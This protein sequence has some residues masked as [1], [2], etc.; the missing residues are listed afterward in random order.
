MSVVVQE[1]PP[2]EVV[3]GVGSGI[4][5]GLPGFPGTA[6]QHGLDG[7]VYPVRDVNVDRVEPEGA[8]VVSATQGRLGGGSQLPLPWQLGFPWWKGW[9]GGK[10][11]DG[12]PGRSVW[13][14]RAP[15]RAY[16]GYVKGLAYYLEH[17]D[18]ARGRWSFLGMQDTAL[19]D[20]GLGVALDIIRTKRRKGHKKGKD[21]EKFSSLVGCGVKW[22]G[23]ESG[24]RPC[25]CDDKR[26]C[27]LC[28]CKEADGLG[29]DACDF[30]YGE[31]L[32]AARLLVGKLECVGSAWEVPL[33]KRLSAELDWLMAVNPKLYRKEANRMLGEMW[34]VI[35]LAYPEGRIGGH[36][37]LQLYGEGNPAEAHFHGH[38]VVAP[39]LLEAAPAKTCRVNNLGRVSETNGW[40]PVGVK[41][42]PGFIPPEVLERQRFDWGRRQINLA[43]RLSVPLSELGVDESSG[44]PELEGDV[45]L[46]YFGLQQGYQK[47]VQRAKGYLGYQ[48]RWPGKDLVSG[49]KGDGSRYTWT[50]PM[51]SKPKPEVFGEGASF[52]GKYV[53]GARPIYERNLSPSDVA[54][55]IWRIDKFPGKCPRLRWRGFLST[56][57]VSKVMDFLGWNQVKVEPEELEESQLDNVEELQGQLEEVQQEIS[58]LDE[59]VSPEE[60]QELQEKLEEIQEKM[61]ELEAVTPA[62]LLRPVGM[63][64]KEGGGGLRFEAESDG[65]EVLIPWVNLKLGPVGFGGE[66][67]T[68]GRTKCWKRKVPF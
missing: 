23:N 39:V 52:T 35:Q 51:G 68:K 19:V 60:I 62:Q 29:K 18:D 45:H 3:A 33:H 9:P 24:V 11:K 5:L 30:L 8:G 20:M 34:E 17:T 48:A 22:F 49:L 38:H 15:I 65:R 54:R 27:S 25:G 67:L 46:A 40:A 53:K 7:D 14:K 47:A 57:N 36:Q 64:E 42:L 28:G 32:E 59:A 44:R 21:E 10:G 50:G 26:L 55:A 63:W 43:R 6:F 1:R 4:G 66:S 58:E 56:G 16:P 2:S 37:S 41:P 12:K 31:F 13:A 61:R